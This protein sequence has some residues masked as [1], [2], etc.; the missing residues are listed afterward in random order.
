MEDIIK[1]D[2]AAL[3]YEGAD[4]VNLTEDIAQWQMFVNMAMNVRI[5]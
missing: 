4:W 1:V 3:G 5:S 2:H